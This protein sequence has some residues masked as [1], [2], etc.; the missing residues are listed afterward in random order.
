VATKRKPATRGAARPSA[1][2]RIPVV[3]AAAIIAGAGIPGL[4]LVG[5]A[6]GRPQATPR[7]ALPTVPAVT[8]PAATGISVPDDRPSVPG[9]QPTPPAIVVPTVPV[10]DVPSVGPVVPVPGLPSAP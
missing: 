6:T 7:P 3:F 9:A 8:A 2:S 4:I 1:R 10:P 5:Q